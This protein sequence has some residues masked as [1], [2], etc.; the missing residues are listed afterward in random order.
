[1]KAVSYALLAVA[2]GGCVAQPTIDPKNFSPPKTAV[3]IDIPKINPAA[4]VGVI[5]TMAP[6]PNWFHF[7]PR[8]DYYFLAGNPQGPVQA[9]HQSAIAAQTQQ[10]MD[11]RM[12]ASP[13]PMPMG[14]I[15]GAAFAG[16]AIGAIIQSSADETFRKSQQF[17]AEILKLYPNYDLRADFMNALVAA[18][19]SHGVATTLALDGGR[20]AP[21]LRWPAVD[22]QKNVLSTASADSFP[23]VD[24]DILVQVSPVAFYNSPGPL[25]SYTRNVSVGIAMYNGRT[26]QFI[27]RQNVWFTGPSG[28]FSYSLYDGM[29][30]DLKDA[31]PALRDA[32]LSLV[33]DVA[34]I[35]AG[36]PVV[37]R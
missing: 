6:G 4:V 23:A 7:S 17:H 8:A 34:E 21:R 30:A 14:Q 36:K 16:A 29:V 28:R 22:E 35:I 32:L 25:N 26:K 33:P 27:G 2:L 18:L 1:M 11:Q 9:D 31:A 12:L 20:A 19:K 37:R 13:T 15:A 3:L 5:T 24:A 10:Q